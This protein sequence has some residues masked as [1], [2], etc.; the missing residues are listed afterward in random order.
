MEKGA[1]GV[2]MS[3]PES[4]GVG[5]AGRQDN[6]ENEAVGD[7]VQD[8]CAIDG[9]GPGFNESQFDGASLGVVVGDESAPGD[10]GVEGF[11]PDAEPDGFCRADAVVLSGGELGEAGEGFGIVGIVTWLNGYIVTWVRC[12]SG[13]RL[14]FAMRVIRFQFVFIGV[15]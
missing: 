14:N 9:L 11:E 5:S 12:W 2:G 6:A 13:R 15:Y 7:L 4:E 10:F 3:G 1:E 8:F